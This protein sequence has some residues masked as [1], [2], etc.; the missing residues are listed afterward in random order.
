MSPAKQE[1]LCYNA[2]GDTPSPSRPSGC[3]I[4]SDTHEAWTVNMSDS[5]SPDGAQFAATFRST[6]TELFDRHLMV[7]IVNHL[8]VERIISEFKFGPFEVRSEILYIAGF[9]PLADC[10]LAYG[11]F[12]NLRASFTFREIKFIFSSSAYWSFNLPGEEGCITASCGEF[13]VPFL[14]TTEDERGTG[15][16]MIARHT[17]AIWNKAISEVVK[18]DPK[19]PAGSTAQLTSSLELE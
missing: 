9:Q 14:N 8:S 17:S 2:C 7:S 1:C 10:K 3:L 6:V 18:P 15:V 16:E 13:Q 4:K 11:F 12:I 5:L 19:L